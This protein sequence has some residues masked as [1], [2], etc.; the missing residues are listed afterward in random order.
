MNFELKT[1]KP[2]NNGDKTGFKSRDSIFFLT[3]GLK[4]SGGKILNLEGFLTHE[5]DHP[6]KAT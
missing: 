1:E 4:K 2:S 6:E 5:E 3:F